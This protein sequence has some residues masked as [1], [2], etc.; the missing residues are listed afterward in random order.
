MVAEFPV[1]GELIDNLSQRLD[2]MASFISCDGIGIWIDGV[3]RGYGATPLVTEIAGLTAFIDS[4]REDE[5]FACQNLGAHYPKADQWSGKVCG[6]LAVPL[7][8]KRGDYMI[9]FRKEAAQAIAWGGDPNKTVNEE[10]GTQRLSPRRSFAAWREEVRG[11]CLPWSSRERLIG[12]TLRVYLLDIIVRFSDV[13]LEERRQSQQRTR[14]VTSELNHRVKGTLDLIR[15]LVMRG[16][17]DGAVKP[18]VRALEGRIAAITLAHEAVSIGN[19][20]DVRGLIEQAIS[21]QSAGIDQV[22]ID[23]LAVK[24]DAKA[25][26]VLA[27]VVHELVSNA[28]QFGALSVP[29]GHLTVRWAVDG[30]GI[31]VLT[32]DE[33]GGP[34]VRAPVADGLGLNIIRRNIPHSLGG[35]SEMKF[36]RSGVKGRFAIPSR[37]LVSAPPPEIT[38]AHK[39][40]PAGQHRLLEGFNLLVLEDQM[41]LAVDLEAMLIERGAATVELAG[42]V[43][44][45]LETIARN[46]PDA[47]ILDIDLGDETSFAVADALEVLGVPFVFAA[48]ELERQFIPSHLRN[49][50]VTPKPYAGD[51]LAELIRDS[52]M[53]HLIRAVL[54]KLV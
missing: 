25:Y 7:S 31:L 43:E 3:W 36:E 54:T 48:S 52:L 14:L 49:V 9:F 11:Q 40:S 8:H 28:V 46:R 23:G 1:Q 42:T 5:V 32:W 33:A 38:D 2:Q 13:I 30:R 35:D 44:K 51:A 20:S 34:P 4:Q 37:F 29:Q 17:D 22:Q 24:L 45:A 39:L 12:D 15:S 50:G 41:L 47:A 21:T 27:L 18:F 53:P 16:A 10:D 19:G 26:T 6:L